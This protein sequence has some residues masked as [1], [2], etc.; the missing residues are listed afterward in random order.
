MW[1]PQLERTQ[2]R[3]PPPPLQLHQILA[4]RERTEHF[5]T[6]C[7]RPTSQKAMLSVVARATDF[8]EQCRHHLPD[9]PADA[10]FRM[11]LLSLQ[12]A[13]RIKPASANQYMTY[14]NMAAVPA[15]KAFRRALQSNYREH[16]RMAAAQP[17]VVSLESIVSLLTQTPTACT[18][19]L[20]L[21][22]ATACRFVDLQNLQM[23][24]LSMEQRDNGW[25][26]A[27]TFV[28]GKTDATH[29]GQ[30]VLV[31]CRGTL[32][33]HFL[34]WLQGVPT[35]GPV[36]PQLPRSRYNVFLQTKLGITSHRIRHSA[37]Q[38][39]ARQTSAADAQAIARHRSMQSTDLYLPP[40]LRASAQATRNA[41]KALQASS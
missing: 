9:L 29:K 30:C 16:D 28:G 33:Q 34:Q 31:N 27:V 12:E 26:M 7:Y 14:W 18:A 23:A 22:F 21:Q 25:E 15:E 20:S 39:V 41:T 8:I 40:E 4:L 6:A 24:H 35:P 11:F 10:G 32:M 36:F 13:G 5:S 37:L 1:G 38:H 17:R 19:A 3:A 2:V